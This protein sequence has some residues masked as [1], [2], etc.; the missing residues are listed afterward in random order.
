MERHF[1][2]HNRSGYALNSIH[3]ST[4]DTINFETS[5]IILIH[6]YCGD[7][8]NA[9]FK[10]EGFEHKRYLKMAQALLLNGYDVISFD[11]SGHGENVRE[12]LKI[13]NFIAD[14]EDVFSWAQKEGYTNIGTVAYSLGGYASIHANLPDRRVS[15]FWAPA[16]YPSRSKSK[17]A[18]FFYKII[19]NFI[20]KPIKTGANYGDVLLSKTFL[21]ESLK[22][23][24]DTTLQNFRIPTLILHGSDDERVRWE[25]SQEAFE[26]MP[27]DENHQ[28]EVIDNAGHFFEK[29]Q[30]QRFID[31][32]IKW[33]KNYL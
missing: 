19:A 8:I 12:P 31:K 23:T 6:G 1:Q 10:R 17:I 24:S 22:G 11:L 28:F 5:L 15:V 4:K 7:K 29:E 18:I 33:I 14:V 20:T 2:I 27:Q 9:G 21:K 32:S 30:L 26:K 13:S 16:L 25:W 3:Y